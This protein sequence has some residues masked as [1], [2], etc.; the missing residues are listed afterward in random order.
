VFPSVIP[1][2]AN[3]KALTLAGLEK[4][5]ERMRGVTGGQMAYFRQVTFEVQL[6]KGCIATSVRKWIP[7][8]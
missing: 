2:V 1:T 6:G 8:K 4:E 7:Q 5:E 3:T